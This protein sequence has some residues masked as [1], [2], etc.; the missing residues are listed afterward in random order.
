MKLH[1]VELS[2]MNLHRSDC[3]LDIVQQSLYFYIKTNDDKKKLITLFIILVLINYVVIGQD[4]IINHTLISKQL[5][6]CEERLLLYSESYALVLN[7]ITY[8]ESLICWLF[9]I[10]I[11]LLLIIVVLAWEYIR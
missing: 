11:V 5:H 2:Y 6:I 9:C 8:L 1:E 10:C 4:Y 7:Y 3:C